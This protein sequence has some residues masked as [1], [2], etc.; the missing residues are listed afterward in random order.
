MEG[1]DRMERIWEVR[2]VS[3]A[4]LVRLLIYLLVHFP[5]NLYSEA[6]LAANNRIFWGLQNTKQKFK[7]KMP[8]SRTLSREGSSSW[9][10][11]S[12]CDHIMLVSGWL[13]PGNHGDMPLS[14]QVIDLRHSH[15][16]AG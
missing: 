11:R 1:W 8:T 4:I 14:G 12:S 16:D 3:C 2:A 5:Q 6:D 13:V 7:F 15:S 9:E 10:A